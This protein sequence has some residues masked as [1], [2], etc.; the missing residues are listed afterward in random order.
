MAEQNVQRAYF[1]AKDNEASRVAVHFNPA[2]LQYQI[3]NT[4]APQGSGA[5]AAQYVSQ[6]SGKLTMD[7]V[8]DTTATGVDVRTHTSKLAALM[9]PVPWRNARNVPAKVQ[10][11][12]GVYRFE[13]MV[14]SYKETF[15]FFAATGIPLRAGVNLTLS[16]QENV[17]EES[18]GGQVATEGDLK[19]QPV[20]LPARSPSAAASAAGNPRAARALAALN[21][22]ESLRFSASA[23]LSVQGGVDL[24][25]PVAFAA[26]AEAG[27]GASA[28]AGINF[29]G[30]ASAGVSASAGAFA[31]LRAAA[32][33][34]VS[35]D[36]SRLLQAS[37]AA[38][39]GTDRGAVFAPGGRAQISGA[40]S[41]RADVGAGAPLSTRL[42]FEG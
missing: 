25:A 10:F 21:G 22:Q 34:A 42:R 16:S 9:K 36:A 33:G 23:S 35:L 26:G 18:A 19:P 20:N 27:F 1:Q 12:W 2:S 3:S 4:L 37:A 7:L 41:L 39:I 13:G 29:G 32:Q 17:F 24:R 38:S 28:G 11:V 40:V 31:G 15:D 5:N 14:E 8:F 6:S 30:S